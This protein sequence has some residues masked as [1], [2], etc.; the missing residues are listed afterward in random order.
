[1]TLND[2]SSVAPRRGV[3][4]GGEATRQAILEAARELFG[5]RAYEQ[6]GLR[7]IAASAGATAALV[8]R[9]FGTKEQLFRE[10]LE[11]GKPYFFERLLSDH[12]HFGESVARIIVYGDSGPP[13]AADEFADATRDDA[14]DVQPA[15]TSAPGN[16]SYVVH[17]LGNPVVADLVREVLER[18]AVP[19]L[20]EWLGGPHA[21]LR[22]EMVFACFAGVHAMRQVVG[23]SA[24]KDAS[25]EELISVLAPMLQACAEAPRES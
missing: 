18:E 2:G 11:S 6:V 23:T 12:A 22:A 1:M 9:Y 14:P 7:D 3:R 24:L 4:G 21:T 10:V 8:N 16:V 5:A 15:P 19:R 17:S 25:A 20:A 13:S